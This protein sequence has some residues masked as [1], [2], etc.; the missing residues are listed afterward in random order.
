MNE[1]QQQQQQLKVGCAALK[2]VLTAITRSNA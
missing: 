1:K 2:F